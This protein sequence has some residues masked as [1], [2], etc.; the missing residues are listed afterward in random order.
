MNSAE[1]NS[2]PATTKT[3]SMSKVTPPPFYDSTVPS[4]SLNEKLNGLN[5]IPQGG[6]ELLSGNDVT[7]L[8]MYSTRDN[9]GAKPKANSS[10]YGIDEFSGTFSYTAPIEFPAGRQNL[11]PIFSLNYNHQ[12]AT[13]GSMAGYG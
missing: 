3:D 7:P 2:M 1:T 4:D 6:E 12:R 11:G 9:A 5:T 10:N 8:D 13:I